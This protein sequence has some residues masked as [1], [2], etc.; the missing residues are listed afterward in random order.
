M[1]IVFSV[2]LFFG[3]FECGQMAYY[4]FFYQTYGTRRYRQVY[5]IYYLEPESGTQ[6]YQKLRKKRKLREILKLVSLNF[7]A[8]L[9]ITISSYEI[10]ITKV[11]VK[12]ASNCRFDV[13]DV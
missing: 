9:H 8:A 1:K 4:H 10:A 7:T 11:I 5:I 2:K 6:W 12:L 3:D 13:G